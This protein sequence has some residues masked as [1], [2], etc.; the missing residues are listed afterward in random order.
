M[1]IK[2]VKKTFGSSKNIN[3]VGK[4]FESFKQNLIDFTKTSASQESNQVYESHIFL[5]NLNQDR[6][7][8]NGN[9]LQGKMMLTENGYRLLKGSYVENVARESFQKH[10]YFK[11]KLYFIKINVIFVL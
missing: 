11:N 3:Y 6:V 1:A 9:I 5:L 7:D 10:S 8:D 4:D 2:P